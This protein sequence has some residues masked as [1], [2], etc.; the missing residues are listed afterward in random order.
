MIKRLSLFSFCIRAITN[1]SRD[2]EY[3]KDCQLFLLL[4]QY[5]TNLHAEPLTDRDQRAHRQ[6]LREMREPAS[7]DA[8]IAV[9]GEYFVFAQAIQSR[10]Y[11]A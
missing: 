7:D 6:V 10:T 5:R 3:L 11:E 2:G 9:A 8:W 4:S 1:L